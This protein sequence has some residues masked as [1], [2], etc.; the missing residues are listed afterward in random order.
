V[1]PLSA[2][3]DVNTEAQEATALEAITRRQPMN[4]QQTERFSTG[5]SELQ[6]ACISDSNI[7]TS[8]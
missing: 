3:M 1:R 2:S 8:S 4:I 5:C 7:V 6:G